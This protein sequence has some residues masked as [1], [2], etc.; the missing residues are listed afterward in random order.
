MKKIQ[1]LLI[2]ANDSIYRLPESGTK[3]YSIHVNELIEKLQS[4]KQTLRSGKYRHKYR[5]ESSNLQRAIEALRY[6]RRNNEKLIEE[7]NNKLDTIVEAIKALSVG[8]TT[9]SRRCNVTGIID[10]SKKLKAI[11]PHETRKAMDTL[12]GGIIPDYMCRAL[13][14]TLRYISELYDGS[15]SDFKD[16]VNVLHKKNKKEK[17]LTSLNKNITD[18]NTAQIMI[19]KL[20]EVEITTQSSHSFVNGM[21]N[22]IFDNDNR[23][24]K[25]EYTI[26]RKRINDELNNS[27]RQIG[28]DNQNTSETII[29]RKRTYLES[30]KKLVINHI[31]DLAKKDFGIDIP[32]YEV[33]MK[34]SIEK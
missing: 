21:F 9:P 19:L 7:E 15:F 25:D 20:T 18:A 3:E 13:S 4:V 23:N 27:L 17:V 1:D 22:L 6:L 26:Y 12:L 14:G 10:A 29:N 8:T 24:N 31:I 11:V 16:L 34:V 33:G 28:G 32:K 2:E 5:K 30:F